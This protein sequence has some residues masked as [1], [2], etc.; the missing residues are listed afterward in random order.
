MVN[1]LRH[2]NY[3]VGKAAVAVTSV[4]S[5]HRLAPHSGHTDADDANAVP[6]RPQATRSRVGGLWAAAVVFAFV[7]LL[8]LIFVL[9]N[10]RRVDV[11]F[12]GVH[13]HPPLGVALLLSAVFGV[14]LVALPGTARI[15]QLRTLDRRVRRSSTGPPTAP[16][17]LPDDTVGQQTHQ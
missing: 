8:L 10:G 16:L 15:V 3:P 6:V 7:L 14:L 5:R 11:S 9:E 17:S 1:S 12:F 2:A 4:R 13:G